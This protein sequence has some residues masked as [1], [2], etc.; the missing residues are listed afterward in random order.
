MTGTK[1]SLAVEAGTAWT[2]WTARQMWSLT[3]NPKES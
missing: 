2:P 3:R 1:V